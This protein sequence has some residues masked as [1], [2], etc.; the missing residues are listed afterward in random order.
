MLQQDPC[1]FLFILYGFRFDNNAVSVSVCQNVCIRQRVDR[2]CGK[3]SACLYIGNV[4]FRYSKSLS[5]NLCRH[6]HYSI[7]EFAE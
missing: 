2:D 6:G 4:D 1:G 7:Q 3:I 5:D